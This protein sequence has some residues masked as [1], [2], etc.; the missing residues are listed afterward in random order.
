MFTFSPGEVPP[1]KAGLDLVANL[2]AILADPQATK[3]H[4]GQM[5]GLLD[6]I[7]AQHVEVSAKIKAHGEAVASTT[8]ELDTRK[9]RLDK[10]EANLLAIGVEVDQ[11]KRAADN[12]LSVLEKAKAEHEAREQS[13]V[14]RERSVAAKE[15]QW[16]SDSI[17][18]EAQKAKI[19]SD[20]Q[21]HQKKV[22]D[23]KAL[24]G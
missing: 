24:V 14:Q 13:L 23:L 2:V 5:K 1:T 3:D 9:G 21:T 15:V 10:H 6:T 19:A 11:K 12:A 18:L 16:R 7:E 4:V 8:Q 22:A 20:I 17:E